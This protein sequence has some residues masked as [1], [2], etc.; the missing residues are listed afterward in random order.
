MRK[1]SSAKSDYRRVESLDLVIGVLKSQVPMISNISNR[2]ISKKTLKRH[3]RN[4]GRLI[5]MLAS[6]MPEKKSRKTEVHN[7]CGKIFRMISTLGLN[8]AFLRCLGPDAHV[9]C[10]SQ[11]GPIFA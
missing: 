11:L 10:E 6:R 4:L 7:F 2:H 1:G 9:A 8:K 5:K 3:L